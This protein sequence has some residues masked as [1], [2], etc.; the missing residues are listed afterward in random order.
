MTQTVFEV[1]FPTIAM[2]IKYLQ[3]TFLHKTMKETHNPHWEFV[4]VQYHRDRV[5]LLYK[6]VSVG[7]RPSAQLIVQEI[8]ISTKLEFGQTYSFVAVV[9]GYL[10][11]NAHDCHFHPC[12]EF[13]FNGHTLI[14]TRSTPT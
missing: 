4:Q 11:R 3:T 7:A 5:T 6:V 8:C 2:T 14:R 9:L 13:S 12:T 1:M 10:L